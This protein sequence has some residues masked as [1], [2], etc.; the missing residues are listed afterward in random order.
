MNAVLY[1][2][3]FYFFLIYDHF[4]SGSL[5]VIDYDPMYFSFDLDTLVET[6]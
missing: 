2:N 3:R 1:Q 6:P 5:S 4:G